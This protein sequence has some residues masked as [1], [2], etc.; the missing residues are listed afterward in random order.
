MI[1]PHFSQYWIDLYDDTRALRCNFFFQE[2]FKEQ[3]DGFWVVFLREN[4]WKD[5]KSKIEFV[6]SVILFMIQ[7]E[8]PYAKIASPYYDRL[9]IFTSCRK[10]NI[11]NMQIKLLQYFR[12]NQENMIWE[13]VFESENSWSEYG[14]LKIMSESFN[15]IESIVPKKSQDSKQ[16]KDAI[17]LRSKAYQ[18]ILKGITMQ[19]KSMIV[20][21]SFGKIDYEIQKNT[22]FIIMPFNENWSDDVC[23]CIKDVCRELGVIP[24]RAD[25][26]LTPGVIID[27]IWAGI[28]QAELIVADITEH[29]ANVFYELGIAH[30]LG[31]D[32]VLLHQKDGA[33]VP[34]DINSRRYVSYGLLPSEFEKF[35]LD[36]HS[37]IKN[38]FGE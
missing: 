32:V 14:W 21:P 29:N 36:L 17:S 22:I 20:T 15:S 19:R 5:T 33:S 35:K 38:F 1:V 6:N 18:R 27:D 7:N 2:L 4:I 37:V 8:I 3:V 34:F 26:F 16:F 24:L 28:N 10:R 9:I 12:F 23:K 11:K 30:T 13:A 31:K 25:D